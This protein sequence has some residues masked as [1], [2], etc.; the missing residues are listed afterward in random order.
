MKRF[1]DENHFGGNSGEGLN[2]N[3][4][5]R[6]N[7]SKNSAKVRKWKTSNRVSK[8]TRRKR[9]GKQKPHPKQSHSVE[10]SQE[11]SKSSLP[12]HRKQRLAGNKLWESRMGVD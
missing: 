7:R 2:A 12:G 5:E 9:A 11:T 8:E 10:S 1:R 6:V 4:K 3:K